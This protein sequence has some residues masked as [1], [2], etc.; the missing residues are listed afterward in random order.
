MGKYLDIAK[1]V[2]DKEAPLNSLIS[3]PDTFGEAFPRTPWQP[4]SNAEVRE[5]LAEARTERAAIQEYDGGLLRPV[6]D[7]QA[8]SLRAFRYALPGQPG[9]VALAH[10][11]EEARAF[12]RFHYGDRLLSVEPYEVAEG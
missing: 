3:Q 11:L 6:A 7:T 12:L 5:A 8:S 1:R 2:L 10:G 9:L 4:G